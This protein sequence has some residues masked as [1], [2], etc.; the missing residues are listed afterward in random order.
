M[1][2]WWA[3][4]RGYRTV[5]PPLKDAPLRVTVAVALAMAMGLATYRYAAVWTPLQRAYLA[6][7]TRSALMWGHGTV[8]LLYIV[9]AKGRRLA[10]DEQ[11]VSITNGTGERAFGLAETAI[12]AGA[13]RLE[14]RREHYPYAALR[15]FLRRWIYRDQSLVDLVA[16]PIWTALVLIL[17][18]AIG[19]RIERLVEDQRE[20]DRAPRRAE[21]PFYG[22]PQADGPSHPPAASLPAKTRPALG[23]AANPKA[24]QTWSGE[25][26]E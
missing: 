16:P 11:V 12:K 1:S 22:A 25:V 2:W 15:T 8:N 6:T 13:T 19:I 9:D 23:R 18:G 26:F 21:A 4:P 20:R 10:L 3:R 24:S 5:Y 17:G 7:Y 14:W